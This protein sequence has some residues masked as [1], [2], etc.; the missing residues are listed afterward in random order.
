MFFAVLPSHIRGALWEVQLLTIHVK[1]FVSYD[2]ALA[3]SGSKHSDWISNIRRNLKQ[4]SG[5]NRGDSW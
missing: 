4:D 3:W 1:D 2:I 5:E